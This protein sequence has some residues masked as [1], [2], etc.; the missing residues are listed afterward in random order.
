MATKRIALYQLVEKIQNLKLTQEEASAY[1]VVEPNASRP[2]DFNVYINP[3]HVD[4][5]NLELLARDADLLL[6]GVTFPKKRLPAKKVTR[7]IVAEGDSWFR[8]PHIFPYPKTCVDFLQASGYQIANV[9]HWGDTLDQMLLAGEFWPYIDG[10]ADLLLFSGGGN[11]ILGNGQLATFLNLF[12]VDHTKP[13][14]ASY[15]VRQ[16]FY[17]NL[18]SV[19]SSLENGLIVPMTTRHANKKIIMHGYDYAIPR[20]GGPWLG[21]AMQYNGLDPTFHAPLCRAIVRLMIDAYN[22]RLGALAAKYNDT[23]LHLDLRGTIGATEW[24]D[25]LHGKEAAAKKI[26]RKLAKMIDAAKATAQQKAISRLYAVDG[27]LVTA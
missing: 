7:R 3:E 4:T 18:R 15:Y 6:S 13:S 22:T 5:T 1:F 2:F 24:F 14:D 11:D 26:A 17:D 8:L 21:S 27:S 9:G 25:E 12:D 19:V 20:S 23:F 16:E 10:E